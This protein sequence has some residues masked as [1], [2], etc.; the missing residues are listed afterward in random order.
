MGKNYEQELANAIT[1]LENETEKIATWGEISSQLNT[2]QEQNNSLQKQN[3]GLKTQ[4]D[5]TC[6]LINSALK[7]QERLANESRDS[8]K[9]L[10]EQNKEFKTQLTKIIYMLVIF[11][12]T[13]SIFAFIR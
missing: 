9:Q 13:I 4:L 11:T 10:I 7:M 3:E 6:Q 12:L 5:N 1:E 2:I 8:F